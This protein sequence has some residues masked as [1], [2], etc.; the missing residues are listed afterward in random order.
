MRYPSVA[1]G[2]A[3]LC[4]IVVPKAGVGAEIHDAAKDG[5]LEQV[6]QCYGRDSNSA[7][8]TDQTGRTP[9]HWACRGV[10]F[11]VVKFLVDHGADVNAVDVNGITPLHS[12]ASRGHSEAVRLLIEKRAGLDFK[13]KLDQG[14]ALHYAAQGGHVEVAKL[15]IEG[16]ARLDARN[17]DERTPLLV[18][19]QAGQTG[20]VAL[21]ADRLKA[22]DSEILNARDFDGNTALHLACLNRDTASVSILLR[23]GANANV[24]NTIGQTPYNLAVDG[25]SKEIVDLLTTSGVDRSPQQFPTLKGPYFG[26]TPPGATPKLF[27]KG[28]I[29]T[30]N[31]VHSSIGFSPDLSEVVWNHRDTICFMKMENGVWTA[32]LRIPFFKPNFG[33]DAPF[34]SFDGNRLY[35][36]AGQLSPE[37]MSGDQDFW[38]MSRT[39]DGW[40][41]P[42]LF[43]SVVNSIPIHWQISMSK[44]GDVYTSNKAIFCS[45]FDNGHYV[46]PQRLPST[47]NTV[48]DSP[49]LAGCVAPFISPDGDYLIFNRFNPRPNFSVDFLISF[50]QSDGGWTESQDFG[51]KLGGGGMAARLSPDGK[52]LFFMSDRPGSARERSIYWVDAK[53]IEEMRPVDLK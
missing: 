44:N 39:A 33:L 7:S 21:I 8:A 50:R 53:V 12:V 38:Y 17:I 20:I 28:I 6:R 9:L 32:P 47:I 11:D 40:S 14:T 49:D 18:A 31:G 5:N 13:G 41:E 52:Y 34:F 30:S 36:L 16:G 2:I 25:N 1:I 43:D 23:A 3:V 42:V 45:R 4:I 35:F 46:T 19:V 29:S 15:L 51:K 37:G 10:H 26:E 27:A 48:P 24:R 22:K